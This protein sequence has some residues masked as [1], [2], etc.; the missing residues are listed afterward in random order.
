[1][2][3]PPRGI[4][5]VLGGAAAVAVGLLF[6]M[7]IVW[8]V[9]ASLKPTH[10]IHDQVG[11]LQ[12]FLPTPFTPGNYVEAARDGSVG[13]ALFNSL[14][15]VVLIAVGGLLV[16]APAAYAFARMRFPGRDLL[17][18]VVVAT[19]I[20]PLEAI[21]V[22]LFI[23]VRGTSALTA[24]LGEH[25]WTLGALSVPFMGKAFNVFLLRQSFLSLPRDLE[26]AAFLD[27]AG[28]GRTFWRV[29]LPNVRHALITVVLLDF[30]IHWNDY[31][32][33]LVICRGEA[34]WTVQFGLGNFF[35]QPPPTPWGP[36][37]A[38]AVVATV[39]VMLVFGLGQRWIVA[40]L[41][42]SGSRE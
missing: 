25:G 17:F 2:S 41:A 34:T 31:L 33:A 30:V 18:V 13:I 32:W 10:A 38:Y 11:S 24:V 3:A 12:S 42:R 39:P 20:V 36:V 28:W 40:S 4:H 6:L 26:E 14:A 29:A 1:M 15:M 27:G 7:P 5:R 8:L 16:N 9:T 35:S 22:P 37:L 21:V 23:T 19:I